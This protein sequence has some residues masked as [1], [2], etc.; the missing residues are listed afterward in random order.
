MNSFSADPSSANFTFFFK[1]HHCA[2]RTAQFEPAE[3]QS[4]TVAAKSLVFV[5]QPARENAA[6]ARR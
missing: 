2:D 1:S 3:S 6:R 4:M 5:A